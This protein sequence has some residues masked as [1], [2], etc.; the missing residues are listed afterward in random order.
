MQVILD[1][2][3]IG[4]S[5]WCLEIHKGGLFVGTSKG[6]FFASDVA[7]NCN[8]KKEIDFTEVQGTKSLT[9]K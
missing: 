7:N 3:L 9:I 2:D 8:D 4:N 6:I 1:Y 5:I